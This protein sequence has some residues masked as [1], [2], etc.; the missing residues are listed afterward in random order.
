[1]KRFFEKYRSLIKNIA[2][3]AAALFAITI[4]VELTSD[5]ISNATL[6]TFIFLM[7]IVLSAFWGNFYTA[8]VV[9]TVAA[10]CFNYFYLPPVGTFTIYSAADWI[11]F[12][13]FLLT[14]IAIS[15]LTASSAKIKMKNAA[16]ETSLKQLQQFSSWLL[17]RTDD[18][19][20]LT[21]V[22]KEALSLFHLQYCSIHVYSEGRWHHYIGSASNIITA[23]IE[24]LI[25]KQDRKM[26]LS[27]LSD[28]NTLGV[29][30]FQINKAEHIFAVL[31]VKDVKLPSES[32][33]AIAYVIGLRLAKALS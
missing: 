22:A 30:Y 24:N 11:A 3:A 9:S 32:L 16:L 18:Q 4:T 17:T 6:V 20:T 27:D 31:A 10:L 13:V 5:N 21:E 1:M 8:V 28:E 15:S 26:N 14:A 33:N 12:L 7:L 2:L 29:R 25:D 23:E 19:L